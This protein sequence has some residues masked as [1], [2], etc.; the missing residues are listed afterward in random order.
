MI[1][2]FKKLIGLIV[3]WG[4]LYPLTAYMQAPFVVCTGSPSDAGG[5]C[6]LIDLLAVPVRI[7]NFLLSGAALVLLAM[8]IWA[9]VRM[10]MY[11]FNEQPEQ[12][13]TAAK[14]TLTR[15]IVGF[16]IVAM[17]ILIINILA[18]TILGLNSGAGIRGLLFNLI[19]F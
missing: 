15:G 13:L 12:E 10:S 1:N 7:F 18:V 14:M 16:A 8:I 9:G 4:V 6:K 5:S 17:A 11:W 19:Y 2:Y 3:G